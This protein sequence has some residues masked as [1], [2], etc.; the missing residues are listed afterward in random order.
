MRPGPRQRPRK[1]ECVHAL[2][3]PNMQANHHRCPKQFVRRKAVYEILRD[4]NAPDLA[5][6]AW[7]IT[8]VE[9][10]RVF[11]FIPGALGWV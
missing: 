9:A 3:Q 6:T 1:S 7:T 11:R 2:C 4:L 10:A 8:K 5:N